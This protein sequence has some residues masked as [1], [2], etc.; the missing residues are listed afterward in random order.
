MCGSFPSLWGKATMCSS[1][2]DEQPTPPTS[3]SGPSWGLSTNPQAGWA[4]PCCCHVGQGTPT[5]CALG[6]SSCCSHPTGHPQPHSSWRCSQVCGCNESPSHYQQTFLP[7][8][9]VS[10]CMTALML[11]LIFQA[12]AGPRKN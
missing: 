3:T 9:S 6:P 5:A 7:K 12:Q 2:L 10:L 1:R 4:L 11:L 8:Y